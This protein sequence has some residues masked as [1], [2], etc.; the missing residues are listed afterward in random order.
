[1]PELPEVEVNR[2][3]LALHT[4][5]KSISQIVVIHPNLRYS[6]PESIYE[7]KKKSSLTYSE[8]ANTYY[9]S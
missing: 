1:M 2:R 8:E 9:S 6:V 3:I 7:V 5:G 4:I